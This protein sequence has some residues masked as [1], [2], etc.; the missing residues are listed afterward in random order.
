MLLELTLLASD[1]APATDL[2]YLLH[3]NP[4]RPEPQVF[5]LAFGR[6]HVF[7]PEVRA[8]RATA[9]L[10]LEV[11]PV[12]LVR[13]PRGGE[14]FALA[15]YVN[16]RPYVASSFLSVAIGEVYGTAL[17]GRCGVRPAL[18]ETALPLAAR[19]AVVRCDEGL[20]LLERLFAPLGYQVQFDLVGGELEMIRL[21]EAV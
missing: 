11:D 8:D 16:D 17:S 5:P 12:G 15:Q 18:A 21:E 9:A 14:G 2:G 3:K 1:A 6:A 4:F 10:M 20:P 13:R 19:L 7:W